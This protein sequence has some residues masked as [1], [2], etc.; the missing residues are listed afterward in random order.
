MSSKRPRGNSGNISELSKQLNILA[1]T[2][3]VIIGIRFIATDLVAP[4]LIA[5][6]FAVLMLPIFNLFRKRGFSRSIS[7]VMMIGTIIVTAS[8]LVII[9]QFSFGLI[10]DSINTVVKQASESSNSTT[11]PTITQTISPEILL[12]YLDTISAGISNLFLYLI[13]IPVLAIVLVSQIDSFSEQFKAQLVK[14]GPSLSKFQKF[15]SSMRAYIIGRFK[16]NL[17][18]AIILTP[19]LFL[20]GVDYAILWGFLTLILSFIPYIGIFIA[21]LGPFLIIMAKHGLPGAAV[22]LLVYL[23]VTTI[24]ENIIDPLVQGK[25]NRLTTMSLIVGFIF[26][27]WLFGILGSIIAAPLTVML[28]T[29]FE[30]YPETKWIALLM[31]GDYS[32]TPKS[33]RDYKKIFGNM[34]KR[35]PKF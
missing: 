27:S 20:V 5:G 10:Q 31:V 30:D 24:T 14:S 2:L 35:I 1:A 16:V 25:E 17:S 3:V 22:L 9:L 8:A 23:I 12:G 21:G 32:K 11:T 7:L 19:I 15:S 33:S 4:L 29:I 6:M 13:L 26:W 18:T 28:K 34:K